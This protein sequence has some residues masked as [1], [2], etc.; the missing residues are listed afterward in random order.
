MMATKRLPYLDNIKGL[1]IILVVIGHAIQYCLPTYEM[2][3][4]FRFIYS[5]HMP[6]FFFVSGY[7]ANRGRWDSNVIRRRAIQLL[8]PFAAWAFVAPLLK[9]GQH[10]CAVTCKRSS[11]QIRACGSCIICLYI[12]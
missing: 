10:G 9:T 7:L 12:P 1:L 4:S 2:N 6:L 3:I 5:F 8:I 11:I